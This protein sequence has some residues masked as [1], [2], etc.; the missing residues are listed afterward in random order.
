MSGENDFH[1]SEKTEVI[2]G[3]E[4]VLNVA[5]E[6]ASNTK[7]KIDV[8][9]DHTRPSLAFENGPINKLFAGA[10]RR[11]VHFRVLTEITADNISSCKK[12]IGL[13]DDLRHLDGI[14]GSFYISETAYLVPAIFHEEG[15]VASQMIYTNVRELV[16][17]Q[18]SIFDTLWNRS[19]SAEEKIKKI[20]EGIQPHFIQTICDPY[21]IQ[22]LGHELGRSSREEVLILYSTA[23]AFLRQWKIGS[24][25]ILREV[26]SR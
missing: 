25:E 3:S 21:Q 2:D 11:G 8:C 15:K 20:E 1:P 4:N 10:K 6:F 23:K 22:K 18:Q 12:L 13:V 16:E 7:T 24:D 14:K 19:I 17:Q 9:L 26:A 5:I